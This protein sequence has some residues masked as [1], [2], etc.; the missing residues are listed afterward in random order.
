[1]A[2]MRA[3]RTLSS[4]PPA[5]RVVPAA[6]GKAFVLDV[7]F[8]MRGVATAAGARWDADKSV[9]VW[10]GDELPAS[11]A[12]FVPASYS[13]EARVQRGLDGVAARASKP[14]GA[15][16]LRSHQSDAVRAILA[17]HTAKRPGFLLADDVGLGKTITTWEAIRSMSSVESVLVVCPL[18]V[19]AHWRR[20]IEAMGDAGKDVVL[21]NYDRLGKLFEI[22][23]EARKKVR[24][25]KGL[26][27]AGSAPEFDVIVWDESH[28]C[29]NPTSARSK[30]AAKLVANAGFCLWLSATAGQNPLELSYLAPLLASVT[31]SRAADLKDFEA[32]CQ[33]QGLGLTRG[34]FGRWEWRGDAGDCA[35]MRALLFDAPRGA[36]PAGVRRRPE[37][38]AGWPEI[39]R[40][41]TPIE[42]A[43]EARSLY[44]EA[45]TKFRKDMELAPRGRD[46]KSALAATLRLRQKSS[47][48]RAPGTVELVQD[49]IANGHQVAVSVAFTETLNAIRDAL[50]ADGVACA[51]IHGGL[52]ASAREEERLRF[53]RGKAPV[54]LF[55]VEEGISLHQGE[56]VDIPRSEVIHDLRWSAIQMA[57][58][59]GR[60]HRD[61]RFAQVYWA[62]ADDTIEDRIARVVAGRIQSM[63]EMVG[64]DVTT[65]REIERLLDD[66]VA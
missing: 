5:S 22:S 47:L 12:A 59:E 19:V 4:R 17:A 26:A 40:M 25:K 57:Q 48:I 42:L 3:K 66:A 27:R 38:I 62:Y 55:T 8:A 29:K 15:I 43:G 18:A 35:K 6:S 52:S 61:G 36:P 20:T 44:L 2:I 58:I 7:S 63:K 51:E 21:L 50:Q 11:L 46:P 65:L 64:D 54:V 28:R 41:L 30:L 53:Q 13:W 37:D 23:A 34:T 32:W 56:H 39:N 60:C 1:M 31:G 45:W 14:Q 16:K 33:G 24:S 49:L 9:F 10:R